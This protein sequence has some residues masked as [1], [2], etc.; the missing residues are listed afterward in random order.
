MI[1]NSRLGNFPEI[2]T[3]LNDSSRG[4]EKFRRQPMARNTNRTVDKCFDGNCRSQRY[5]YP[6]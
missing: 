2:F 6:P 4:R 3:P 1:I 5:E